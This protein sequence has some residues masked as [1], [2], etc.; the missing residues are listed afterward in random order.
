[1]G[2]ILVMQNCPI[3]KKNQ[4]NLPYQWKKIDMIVSTNLEKKVTEV[5]SVF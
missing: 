4:C 1:M 2:C 3:L 5:V